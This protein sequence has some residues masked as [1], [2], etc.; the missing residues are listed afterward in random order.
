MKALPLLIFGSLLL[1]SCATLSK[2]ECLNADWLTIGYEDGVQGRSRNRIGS[3]RK[4][5]AEHGITPD[6]T[7]YQQGYHKGLVNFCTPGNGYRRGHRGFKYTGVCQGD[8]EQDFLQGYRAGREIYLENSTLSQLN[9]KLQSTEK[10][11]T[12]TEQEIAAE[13]KILFSNSLSRRERKS[14][15]EQILILK[16]EYNSLEADRYELEEDIDESQDQ[17]QYLLEK[18]NEYAL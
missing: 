7:A 4:A 9:R 18:Y 8:F 14:V 12:E 16:D 1:S 3:H 5:C 17:L 15:Y 11:L 6:L 2:N 13:E 10:K